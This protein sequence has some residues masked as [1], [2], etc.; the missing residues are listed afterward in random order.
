[1]REICVSC[2]RPQRVCLCTVL[3]KQPLTTATKII[4][5][6]HPHETRHKLS[7]V[8]VVARCLS[9][10][11][12]F[13][14]RKYRHGM[15]PLL[16]ECSVSFSHSSAPVDAA[17]TDFLRS[18]EFKSCGKKSTAL[19]LFPTS[20]SA[21]LKTWWQS[22][23]SNILSSSPTSASV[24]VEKCSVGRDDDSGTSADLVEGKCNE[25]CDEA[26]VLLLI[27][28]GTWQHA[29][30]MVKASM[31]FLG[32]FVVQVSLPHDVSQKGAGMADSD[33][34]LRKEPFA[35]CVST[36]EAIARALAI[37]EPN[38]SFIEATLLSVLE[39]MVKIQ[40]S[41]F[42]PLN[43]RP[44]RASRKVAVKDANQTG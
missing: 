39:H 38:G 25:K 16:D 42:V 10:C 30:E 35:G 28:D 22:S 43:P 41:H 20:A 29:K 40:T 23:S 37:L 13:V 9:N 44:F 14:G 19:L 32:D 11:E 4:I 7:T 18:G 3:P 36:M 27:V 17:S 5:L 26:H 6:Q 8:A 2:G 12:V 31:P 33:S 24:V 34:I 1:M 21:D 15:C